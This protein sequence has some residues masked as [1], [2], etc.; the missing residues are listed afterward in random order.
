M[1]VSFFY[2]E[3][4]FHMASINTVCFRIKSKIAILYMKK[5]VLKQPNNPIRKQPKKLKASENKY[6]L[7]L[8]LQDHIVG[9][10]SSTITTSPPQEKKKNIWLYLPD[11]TLCQ[12]I[13]CSWVHYHNL[14]LII[15]LAQSLCASWNAA[16][17]LINLPV[18]SVFSK[19]PITVLLTH[20]LSIFHLVKSY[21][22]EEPQTNVNKVNDF[23]E[24]GMFLEQDS[25]KKIKNHVSV[26]DCPDLL[27]VT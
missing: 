7:R 23:L 10:E 18:S 11:T 14:I 27:I 21:F 9:N 16:F 20:S 6:A 3:S 13:A 8:H 1:S 15:S 17:W 22:P 19:Q 12:H 26:V 25:L 24:C 5:Y 2:L 4:T